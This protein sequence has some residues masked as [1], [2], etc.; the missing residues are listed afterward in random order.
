MRK[1]PI[2]DTDLKS[3]LILVDDASMAAHSLS[4]TVAT[5]EGRFQLL[6]ADAG[7]CFWVL[8]TAI[9]DKQC[10][11]VHLSKVIPPD[12]QRLI[13]MSMNIITSF[14]S[15]TEKYKLNFGSA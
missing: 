2:M 5:S 13:L 9:Q 1:H 14:H 7:T 10:I 15:Y 3:C 8:P 6:A 4:K 11:K 12:Y